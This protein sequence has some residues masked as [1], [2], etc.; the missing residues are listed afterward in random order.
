[1]SSIG[2]PLPWTE[3]NR[4]PKRA[5]FFFM[6]P[7]NAQYTTAGEEQNEVLFVS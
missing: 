5:Q 3:G 4:V 2:F 6:F 1:M 7:V